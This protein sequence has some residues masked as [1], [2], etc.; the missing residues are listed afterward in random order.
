MNNPVYQNNMSYE[1]N[2]SMGHKM[3]GSD[4]D[5]VRNH[6]HSGCVRLKTALILVKTYDKT[7]DV[8]MLWNLH[9][10]KFYVNKMW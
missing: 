3:A 5:M 2:G 1:G 6:T 10:F 4:I 9:Y 7:K 8:A